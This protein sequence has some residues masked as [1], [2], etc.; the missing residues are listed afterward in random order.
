MVPGIQFADPSEVPRAWFI[1][2]EEKMLLQ[3]QA[4]RFLL[5]WRREPSKSKYPHF[6]SIHADFQQMYRTFQEFA[7]DEGLGEIKPAACEM[8]YINLIPL[9]NPD[10]SPRL[11]QDVLRSWR[12]DYG[13]GWTVSADAVNWQALYRLSGDNRSSSARL[14]ATLANLVGP[15][16]RGLQLDLTVHGVPT[17]ETFEAM[18]EFHRFA[19][20]TIVR[21]FGAATTDAAH[22]EWELLT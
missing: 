22:E 4:D 18:V 21:Y 13:A 3:L 15:L 14:T 19:H 20:E 1:D 11:I 5:N 6:E 12:E 9:K 2:A 7:S 8:S 16:G 17:A 10:G